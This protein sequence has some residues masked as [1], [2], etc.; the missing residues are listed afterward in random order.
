MDD[1]ESVKSFRKVFPKQKENPESVVR[2]GDIMAKQKA[3]RHWSYLE[4][5]LQQ[6][7]VSE[8]E[9]D[10]IGFHYRTAFIHGWK[11]GVESVN[12]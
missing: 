3:A 6:H 4:E 2:D 12:E 8:K 11:H 9:I 5:V 1:R 10:I 7:E